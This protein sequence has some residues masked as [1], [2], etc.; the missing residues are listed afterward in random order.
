MWVYPG[1]PS[2]VYSNWEEGKVPSSQK[3]KNILFRLTFLLLLILFSGKPYDLGFQ[4]YAVM[5]KNSGKWS[6]VTKYEERTFVCKRYVTVCP[7]VYRFYDG[8]LFLETFTKRKLHLQILF[9]R[10][11]K[12]ARIL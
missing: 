1:D 7:S 5:N 3:I 12:C 9:L 10:A 8:E 2:T 6:D 4:E 11:R